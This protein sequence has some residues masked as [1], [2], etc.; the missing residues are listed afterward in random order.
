MR[1]ELGA[2]HRDRDRL[3]SWQPDGHIFILC[4]IKK[5]YDYVRLFQFPVSN[6]NEMIP[7]MQSRATKQPEFIQLNS[8]TVLRNVMHAPRNGAVFCK[9]QS[10]TSISGSLPVGW[11][12]VTSHLFRR[13]A[14]DNEPGSIICISYHLFMCSHVCTER[15]VRRWLALFLSNSGSFCQFWQMKT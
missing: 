8:T 14:S 7:D 1:T 10:V 15:T 11:T 4:L 13:R 5:W 2:R 6:W 3:T 9:E 12:N